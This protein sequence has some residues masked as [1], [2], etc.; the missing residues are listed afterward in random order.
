M[1]AKQ[2]AILVTRA[3]KRRSTRAELWERCFVSEEPGF[4]VPEGWVNIQR[5]DQ[6]DAT[7]PDGTDYEIFESDEDAALAVCDF[8]KTPG[9]A[10]HFAPT[11]G[12]WE[13]VSFDGCG[14]SRERW[15][16]LDAAG[17]V[18]DPAHAEACPKW[19][20]V[21]PVWV[22]KQAGLM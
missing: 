10:M 22:A 9:V 7:K 16:D 11:P 4:D 20:V 19:V 3:K 12:L 17:S 8:T 6:I 5:S 14:T 1:T 2:S 18:I 15:Y 21:I 13:P